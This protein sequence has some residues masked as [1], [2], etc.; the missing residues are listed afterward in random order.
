MFYAHRN[1]ARVLW[2][3][4][5]WAVTSPTRAQEHDARCD[6]L[7]ELAA[8]QLAA[9]QYSTM[10]NTAEDRQR[11]CPGPDSAF[12]VGLAQA[13][14]VDQLVISDPAEREMMRRSA[15]RNLRVAAAGA[16]LK[17]VWQ[18]TV[19]DWI[20]HLQ[21]MAP[22]GSSEPEPVELEPETDVHELEPLDVPPAPPPQ[23][24]PVFPWGPV[25]GGVI[26][27][28]GLTTGLVLGIGAADDREKARSA[29]AQLRLL[30]DD[31]DPEQLTAAIAR[32]RALNDDAD[33]KAQWSAVF[34]IGGAVALV[35][36]IVW[37][38]AAEP[39]GKWRWAAS[40]TELQATVRF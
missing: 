11:V 40:P 22:Y 6:A 24:Q 34:L 19:H 8:R 13:N 23:A 7:F 10:L 38:V 39:E 4:G 29:S 5:A 17:A 36:S 26:G 16:E 32:T 9:E 15:L 31:L 3:V 27:L 28:G 35:G 12:L 21:A 37:Y 25:L 18:F 20:V 2:L 14:L 33:D 30:A 1:V